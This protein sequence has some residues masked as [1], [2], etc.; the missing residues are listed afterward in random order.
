MTSKTGTV[1]EFM[2]WTKQIVTDTTAAH[3]TPKLWFDSGMA[4]RNS[5]KRQASPEALIK[6]LSE[7]NLALLRVIGSA[8]PSSVRALAYLVGRKQP[9]LS[10]TLK[11]LEEAGIVRLVPGPKRTVAPHLLAQRVTLDLDL[12]GTTTSVLVQVPS[13]V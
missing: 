4:A 13:P 3:D 10:R 1:G 11:R 9:N 6:L 7:E 12:V 5:A 2:R 8:K